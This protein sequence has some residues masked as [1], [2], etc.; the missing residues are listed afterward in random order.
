[1]PFK[2]R[3]GEQAGLWF[4]TGATIR[5][6]VRT[7]QNLI[8]GKYFAQA[9]MHAIQFSPRLISPRQTGLIRGRDQNEVSVFEFLQQWSGV[10]V[11][12]EILQR[13]RRD[14]LLF[15]NTNG[16]Q[17]TIPLDKYSLLHT[18]ERA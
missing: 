2:S 17:D 16:I 10:F 11:R 8:Q 6:V 13:Q 5:F 12:L 18:P 3:L 4:P 14:L 7:N 1:M 9:L 15:L